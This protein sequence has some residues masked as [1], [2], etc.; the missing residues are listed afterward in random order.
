M[1]V[2]IFSE[3]LGVDEDTRSVGRTNQD[4]CGVPFSKLKLMFNALR[5]AK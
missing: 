5:E 2:V 3:L 1:V 4:V